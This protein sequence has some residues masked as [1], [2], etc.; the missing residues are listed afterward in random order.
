MQVTSVANA[1]LSISKLLFTEASC[2]GN[3]V[4]EPG[5]LRVPWLMER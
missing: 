4:G 2:V 3:G 5:S 1:H